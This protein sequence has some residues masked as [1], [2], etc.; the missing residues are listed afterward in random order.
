[1]QISRIPVHQTFLG[2][3][4]STPDSYITKMNTVLATKIFIIT[5]PILT[6]I[7]L[8]QRATGLILPKSSPG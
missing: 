4:M 2:P 1:M 7:L 5:D 6:I 8:N 3:R